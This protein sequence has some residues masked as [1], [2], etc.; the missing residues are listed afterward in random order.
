VSAAQGGE[1]APQV[2]SDRE[3]RFALQLKLSRGGPGDE[4]VRDIAAVLDDA[5]RKIE[6]S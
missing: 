2:L 6:Q 5:A 4:Q 1:P 3:L